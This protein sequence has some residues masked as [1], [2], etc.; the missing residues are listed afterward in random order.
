[1]NVIP[2]RVEKL[3]DIFI[4]ISA[5]YRRPG[6]FVAI[7]MEDRK[8]RAIV[9][10]VQK[11]DAFPRTF[12]RSRLRFSIADYRDGD[13]VGIIEDRP[14]RMREDVAQFTPLIY[15]AGSLDAR[16]AWNT[17]WRGKLAEETPQSC[18]V[19]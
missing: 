17:P 1:M 9:D 7:Q 8:Y 2:V 16:M 10:G 19:W 6:N 12:E 13:E 3:L 11:L 14:K 15:R 4:S 5:Q 18:K